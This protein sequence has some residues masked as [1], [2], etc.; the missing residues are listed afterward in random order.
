MTAKLAEMKNVHAAI[1]QMIRPDGSP[2]SAEGAGDLVVLGAAPADCAR[3]AYT[4]DGVSYAL[5]SVGAP[6]ELPAGGYGR[7]LRNE[8]DP[9]I[10]EMMRITWANPCANVS[11]ALVASPLAPVNMRGWF[12]GCCRLRAIDGLDLVDT[13]QV[14]DMT[15]LFANCS[16]LR[17]LDLSHFDTHHV[18]YMVGMFAQCESLTSLDLSSFDTSLVTEM[19]SMF[20][21]CAALRELDLSSFNTGNVVCMRG[22]FS[23]CSSLIALDLSHFDT[24]SVER[25]NFMFGHCE[26][27]T[28]LDVSSFNTRRVLDMVRMF[29]D[30]SSLAELDLSSFSFAR[31][32]RISGIVR[33]CAALRH[34]TMPA[35]PAELSEDAHAVN[36]FGGCS[37]LGVDEGDLLQA[38]FSTGVRV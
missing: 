37:S 30:C 3:S 27:L 31:I 14:T 24:R 36:M 18:A 9:E 19:T 8:D 28:S 13:S 34:L 16:A 32:A 21:N 25:M 26:S 23:Y 10:P 38:F 29:G 7:V 2:F 17:S 22:M 33:G 11:Y 6:F 35:L 4:A 15:D 1:Y 20:S 5:R 12:A